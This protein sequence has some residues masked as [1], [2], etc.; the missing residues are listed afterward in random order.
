[1]PPKDEGGKLS[2]EKIAALEQWVKLGAPDPRTG[3]KAHPM[4]MAAA[5]KH[6]A[7][8]PV[9]KPALPAVRNS[10]WVRTPVDQFVLAKLEAKKLKPAAPAD[11]RML[12]RRVTYD[13]TGLP[14]TPEEM[15]TFLRDVKN[16]PSAYEIGR[17]HV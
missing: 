3:G 17:A 5:R 9:V 13:L 6:W 1:M 16:D 14:P 4:D 12:L 7:F 15:E 2:A 11:A 10:A 8:Q